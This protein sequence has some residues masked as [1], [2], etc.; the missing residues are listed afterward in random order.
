[1]DTR[2]RASL[3]WYIHAL[4]YP[5]PSHRKGAGLVRVVVLTL[6]LVGC[7]LSMPSIQAAGGTRSNAAAA[8]FP[9][10]PA[11]QLLNTD[12]TLNVN[13]GWSGALDPHGWQ[14][15]LDAE[16]GPLL[17]PAG[18]SPSEV[19]ANIWMALGTGANDSVSAIAVSGSD[20]YVGGSF[21]SAGGVT[22]NHIAKWD[23]SAWSAL[24]TGTS[25]FVET[26]VVSGSDVYV[27]GSFTSAGGVA[28]N[29]IAKWDGSAWSALGN[30]LGTATNTSVSAIAV[31]GSDVYV[32]GTFTSASGVAANCIAR[33]DGSAWSALGTGTNTRVS[34]IAV[35]GSD[36]YVG[37]TFTST[38]G[39]AANR[40]AKWDGSA[41]SALGTG[42]S[43]FVEAIAISGSDVYVGGFFTSAGGAAANRIAK[44]DGSAWSALGAGTNAYVS[45]I[46]VSGNDVY[47]GGSFTS[48]G[49]VAANRIAKWDGSAWSVLGTGTN[50]N[51]SAIVVSGSDV[52]VGG[53]FT[54]AG[55]VANT[56][57][58]AR[59]GLPSTNADLS[60]LALSSGTLTPSFAP[61]TT[62]YMVSVAYDVTNITVTPTASDM[63]AT[64]TVNGTPLTSGHAS[65]TISLNVGANTITIVVTAQDGTATK[66]YTVA[67]M[68]E[69]TADLSSLMLSSGT[70]TPPFASGTTSYH[71]T[72]A[73]CAASI[74]VMPTALDANTTLT[75]NGTP[76]VSGHASGAIALN[77]GANTV[78]TVV[79]AQD[80]TM[81][82]MYTVTVTRTAQML[83]SQAGGT[84]T[85]VSSPVTNSAW[86]LN[87]VAMVS[88][89]VGWAVGGKGMSPNGVLYG[90]LILR[91]NGNSWSQAAISDTGSNSY[92]LR[93]IAMLSA[94]NGMAV[95]G[96]DAFGAVLRWD[97]NTWSRWRTD[98]ANLRSLAIL[99][100]AGVW[101]VGSYRHCAVFPCDVASATCHWNGTV[102]HEEFDPHWYRLNSV[103]M[104]SPDD[105]WAVGESGEIKHWDG[106][107]WTDVGSYESLFDAELSGNGLG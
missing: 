1:M 5:V 74:T 98:D 94:N 52:Y 91:W 102:W 34:A 64:I 62:A 78:T 51:V 29:H 87:S 12:G 2:H 56:S 8:P 37:G 4:P 41:W 69:A 90:P 71:A 55:G 28:A 75:V 103:A 67:V 27:G 20:V 6:I 38:G 36:V 61:G 21:T 15:T 96:A 46:V 101:A 48:A 17:L 59:Y 81:T 16:R 53:S 26:I 9:S 86:N 89:S 63:H 19:S 105:G 54:S 57:R 80:G 25:G 35:S 33:W 32:G 18:S 45:V 31:S 10:R 100:P 22:A 14:V 68:R 73:S 85:K 65:G 43:S 72:V 88:S 49:D 47:V 83:C 11:E 24:G 104:V 40:I 30:G 92:D 77:L 107:T 93:S 84:W 7:V 106:K 58:I 99:S 76:V 66:T 60:S 97:G 42:T 82:K 70:L 79:T 39:V 95:G 23:G 44:W 13:T 3:I 50:D